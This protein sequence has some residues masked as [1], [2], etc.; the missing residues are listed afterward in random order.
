[1][2]GRKL[3]AYRQAPNIVNI[4]LASHHGESLLV[5]G[6]VDGKEMLMV[7]D[8]GASR[9]IISPAVIPQW[10]IREPSKRFRVTTASGEEVPV[11]GECDVTLQIGGW[12]ACH[13]ALV[14]DITDHLLLGLDVLGGHGMTLD[15]N[16][17]VLRVGAEE[18]VMTTSTNMEVRKVVVK[19]DIHVEALS[20]NLVPVKILGGASGPVVGIVEQSKN[21][22]FAKSMLVSKTLIQDP[23]RAV[24]RIANLKSFTQKIAKGTEV[25]LFSPVTIIRRCLDQPSPVAP[26]YDRAFSSELQEILKGAS[27]HLDASQKRVVKELLNQYQSVFVTNQNDFGRTSLVQHRIDTGATPPIRQPPRRVP[28]AKQQEAANLVNEMS[29]AGVI[30]PSQSPWA[31]PVVLVKKKDGTTRFCVDYRRLN[32]VT[33][34]D[35]YPLPRIDDTLDTLAGAKWFSTLDLKSGYWQVELDPRDKEKTAF[36]TGSGLWQ[37]KVMPFGLCNAPATFERLMETVLRGLHWKTCLV[38]LDDVIVLGR[39]FEDHRKNLA[40]VFQKLQAADLKLNPKKCSLFKK[41]VKYLGHVI[42]P[43]GVGTDPEKTECIRNWCVPADVHQLRSFLG[44][45]TYYRRFVQGFAD[46]ARPLH[47]LT[48]EKTP[49]VWS[50]ACQTA[51]DTL[52]LA[53]CSAPILT[54]PKAGLPFIVDT[55]ASNYGLGGVLSQVQDGQEKVVAYFSKTLSKAERNYCVTRKE[56]LAMVKTL[57]HFHKYLYGQEFLLRTDHASLKW[58]LQFKNPEGQ[59]ARWLER[60]QQYHFTIEHRPGRQHNNADALS[61]R[62]CLASKCEHCRRAEQKEGLDSTPCRQTRLTPSEPWDPEILKTEQR[63]DPHIRPIY[64]WK[65]AGMERPGWPEVSAMSATTKSYWAQW[66]SLSIEDGLLVRNWENEDGSQV[67]K[68]IV[69]PQTKVKEVLQEF[70]GGVAGGHLGAKKT[71]DKVRE[72]FYWLRCRA[73]VDHW[74]KTCEACAA[75]KGPRTRTRGKMRQYNVGAP[76]ERVAVDVAGPFPTTNSGNKYLLVTMDYFSKWPEVYP[77]PNQ[78]ATTVAE[79][80]VNEFFCRFGVPLEL[81][82]DQGRNFES[83]VFREV[84]KLM[85]IRKTR[86]TPLH[87]QSDGMVERFNATLQQHLR[88]MVDEHQTDW[89]RHVP[90]FLMA[91]RSAVHETTGFTPAQVMFGRELRLPPDVMFGRPPDQPCAPEG[92]VHDLEKRLSAV[93]D[94]VRTHI[95]VEGDRM[96]TRYDLRANSAGFQEGDLVWLYNPARTKGRS[97]KLQR[98]WEGPYTVVKRIN[99]VV[100]RIQRG[101][102][103]KMKVVHLHRLAP[104][105]Q[106]VIGDR[107]DHL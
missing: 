77:I 52:K 54:F 88:I 19:E 39:T 16:N 36:T 86:T 26:R 51:F 69:L 28:L 15:L 103:Q 100:Y 79:V 40:E 37:F 1:M 78:E 24:V 75:S 38:Y 98:H 106:R 65:E 7:V 33:K 48:E 13:R 104:Y 42:S 18:V 9:T 27:E 82:S 95:R 10:R 32:D 20:E 107:D 57:E 14:A 81:H 45:C 76:L 43:E 93:H 3:A 60:L 66:N 4:S 53:L 21:D 105:H 85:G 83:A 29:A 34:K 91:Y 23:E 22:L 2:R 80:L 64:Q 97:P 50:E 87:P 8:T 58:L 74:C 72:R 61:R 92:F 11:A 55:D 84:C 70:H 56:L 96:K 89:D 12:K 90:L 99:D 41:T 25:G 31:S 63:A 67:R 102:R 62:P 47:R 94:L 6:L 30:E 101:P 68:Q 49:F 73:D 59:I 35:S 5:E 44:L 46:I 17:L 71:L